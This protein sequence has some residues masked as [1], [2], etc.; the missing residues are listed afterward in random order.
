MGFGGTTLGRSN[1][2]GAGVGD[3][4]I[5]ESFEYISDA[6]LQAKWIEGGGAANPLRDDTAPYYGQYAMKVAIAGT[7]GTVYREL[8]SYDMSTLSNLAIATRSNVGGETIRIVL[9]DSS[10]N[11][12]GWDLAIG[13]VD[14]WKWH[15]V[16]IHTT[17]DVASSPAVDMTDIVK[18]ELASL[19]AGSEFL[20]DLIEFDSIIA[21]KIGIGYDGLNDNKELGSSIRGHLL[22]GLIHGTG[23]G[24][25]DNKS[26]Y[27][28]IALDRLDAAGYGLAALD[29]ELGLIPQSGGATVWNATALQAIQDEAEDALEGED[30]DHLLKL[31]DAAQP[32][33]VNCATDSILAKLIA[34]GDPA[35]P[36][37]FDCT[38]DSLAIQMFTGV[39][40][41]ILSRVARSP[42]SRYSLSS[43]GSTRPPEAPHTARS[44]CPGTAV[45]TGSMRQTASQRRMRRTR[46]R[47]GSGL[48]GSSPRSLPV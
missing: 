45:Q 16:Y 21:S 43:D 46:T 24:I 47:P 14:T 15:I 18:I 7:E 1:P 42:S 10:G 22:A 17:P 20:F 2:G 36:S 3:I 29:T 34:K 9:Y 5:W 28:L 40:T 19:D 37:T 23:V 41:S 12:S 30:L 25:P 38:T 35:V 27:E 6:A 8:T 48:A 31:D 33:P 32:Y 44:R 11:Y 39:R 26:L 13:A 4:S